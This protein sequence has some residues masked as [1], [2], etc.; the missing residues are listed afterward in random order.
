ML[1]RTITGGAR[2]A[3]RQPDQDAAPAARGFADTP[4]D[5]LPLAFDRPGGRRGR[6]GDTRHNSGTHRPLAF[7]R[8]HRHNRRAAPRTAPLVLPISYPAPQLPAPPERGNRGCPFGQGTVS[9]RQ[10]PVADAMP[11]ADLQSRRWPRLARGGVLGEG[12]GAP[13]PRRHGGTP[14]IPARRVGAGSS[15]PALG[16]PTDLV[17]PIPTRQG[18]CARR[19]MYVH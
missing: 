18:T 5:S 3:F 4:G 15:A 17:T 14:L 10:W 8:R 6:R 9:G 2:C 13:P 19:P 7:Q 16:A 11:R 12:A 1:G